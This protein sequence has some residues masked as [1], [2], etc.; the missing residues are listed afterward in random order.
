MSL[1]S[2]PANRNSCANFRAGFHKQA[3]HQAGRLPCLPVFTNTRS[4]QLDYPNRP[5]VSN[6]FF[7]LS[8]TGS[9]NFPSVLH[10]SYVFKY[11]LALKG[12]TFIAKKCVGSVNKLAVEEFGLPNEAIK[13]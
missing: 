1:K 2:V 7:R 5:A 8:T 4:V 9:G 12:N 10:I 11:L 6:I 13:S 3:T